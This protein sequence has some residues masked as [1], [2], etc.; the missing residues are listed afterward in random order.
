MKLD[1]QSGKEGRA[2][3]FGMTSVRVMA[4]Q[5]LEDKVFISLS[6]SRIARASCGF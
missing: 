5:W 1:I 4:G 3:L 6:R 2:L